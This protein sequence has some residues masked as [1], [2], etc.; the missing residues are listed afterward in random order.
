MV[1]GTVDA[2]PGGGALGIA[3]LSVN[4][5]AFLD[6]KSLKGRFTDMCVEIE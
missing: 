5:S 2:L 6:S 1:L 4:S 3:E